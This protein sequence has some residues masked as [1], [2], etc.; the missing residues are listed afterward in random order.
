MVVDKY[1]AMIMLMSALLS[2]QLKSKCVTCGRV[3]ARAGEYIYVYM[4][5]AQPTP[6]GDVNK[7]SAGSVVLAAVDASFVLALGVCFPLL[8]L[9]LVMLFCCCCCC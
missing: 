8:L 7:S 1:T 4:K 3:I 2:V 5:N 9:L 6:P